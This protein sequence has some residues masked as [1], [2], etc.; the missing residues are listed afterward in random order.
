MLT[1]IGENTLCA[2]SQ[3]NLPT[4][5]VLMIFFSLSP[6]CLPRFFAAACRRHRRTFALDQVGDPR[7]F[8][9]TIGR[10]GLGVSVCD[11]KCGTC[12][13]HATRGDG[14]EV[15]CV[16]PEGYRYFDIISPSFRRTTWIGLG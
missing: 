12:S 11:A 4:S 1:G 5:L 14:R 8:R 16:E 3:R 9:S 6:S 13:Y 2:A 10:A 15:F 7:A